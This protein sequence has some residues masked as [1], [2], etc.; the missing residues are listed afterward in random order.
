MDAEVRA[1]VL[2]RKDGTR[3][4]ESATLPRYRR[5]TLRRRN[6][7]AIVAE[8]SSSVKGCLTRDL[9]RRAAARLEAFESEEFDRIRRTVTLADGTTVEAWTF[10]ASRQAIPSAT[11]WNLATWQQSHTREFLRRLRAT[12]T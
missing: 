6:Y 9:D 3:P 4:V 12:R 10:E 5:V 2:G 8:R 7:P 1:L 11:S